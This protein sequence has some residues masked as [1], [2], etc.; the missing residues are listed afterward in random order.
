[1]LRGRSST[2]AG[3]LLYP[4]NSDSSS[5]KEN[6]TGDR[7]GDK[8][9]AAPRRHNGRSLT[10]KTRK[11]PPW[12]A[13]DA[14]RPRQDL[15]GSMAKE[16]VELRKGSDVCLHDGRV[17]N[18]RSTIIQNQR[19]R[20]FRSV[21]PVNFEIARVECFGPNRG[22][23]QP[24]HPVISSQQRMVSTNCR[25]SGRFRWSVGGLGRRKRLLHKDCH[26][27]GKTNVPRLLGRIGSSPSLNRA[28]LCSKRTARPIGGPLAVFVEAQ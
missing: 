5:H 27:T 6:K 17:S 12:R 10:R 4:D 15:A 13:G 25:L 1:M 28:S 16:G 14:V 20:L 11:I 26:A 9:T 7:S 8:H 22:C 24:V 21:Q 2:L 19:S 18:R 23:E 3:K